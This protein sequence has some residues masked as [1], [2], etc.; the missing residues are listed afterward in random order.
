[1][2]LKHIVFFPGYLF[3]WLAYISP[4]E[5]G[6]PRNVAK[7]SRQWAHRDYL[8][9]IYSIVFYGLIIAFIIKIIETMDSP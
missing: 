9:P 5:W 2:S 6:K 4:K 3:L 1:M 8:A 7:S